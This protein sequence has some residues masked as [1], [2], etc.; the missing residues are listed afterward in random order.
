MCSGEVEVARKEPDLGDILLHYCS[1]GGLTAVLNSKCHACHRTR[2]TTGSGSGS[3]D[4]GS[5]AGVSDSGSGVFFFRGGGG[6][7]G[8]WGE[9]VRVSIQTL[10]V[11]GKPQT[12][13]VIY[14]NLEPTT[15]IHHDAKPCLKCCSR[16]RLKQAL[17]RLN[18]LIPLLG[19]N[20]Q[21]FLRNYIKHQ[22]SL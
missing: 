10:T 5:G 2:T 19:A 14:C 9:E 3:G 18:S 21:F 4:Q 15:L 22:G 1:P 8:V 16:H 20:T 6:G 17:Q 12:Q 7:W 13:T 11:R